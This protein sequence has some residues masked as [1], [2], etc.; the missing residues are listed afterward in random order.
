MDLLQLK[1]VPTGD[2]SADALTKN[3][4][5]IL[6][7]RHTDFL[8]GKSIPKFSPIYPASTKIIAQKDDTLS[9]GG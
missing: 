1:R 4:P 9:T 2:N 7:N 8:L 6:F 3:T 5:R